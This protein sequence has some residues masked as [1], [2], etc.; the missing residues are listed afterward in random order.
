MKKLAVLA[1]LVA[2]PLS[3]SM[4]GPGSKPKKNKPLETAVACVLKGM[5]SGAYSTMTSEQLADYC[6]D[7]AIRVHGAD[8][9]P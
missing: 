5:E 9:T 2:L 6:I 4:A 7:A 1:A 8:Y 3:A